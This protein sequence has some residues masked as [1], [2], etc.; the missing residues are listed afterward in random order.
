VRMPPVPML[1]RLIARSIQPLPLAPL[2]LP[3]AL[4]LRS[5]VARHPRIFE[6]L[7]PHASK[8]FGIEPTDLP[9]AFVLEPDPRAPTVIAVRCLPADISIRIAGSM[10]GLL[11]LV[12][13]S[14]DGDALFFSRDLVIKGDVE[15]VLALRNAIDDADLDLVADTAAL[16]GPLAPLG[17]CLLGGALSQ[18]KAL[19][20]AAPR[21]GAESWS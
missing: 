6:R 19:A 17:R 8:R 3:L 18:L 12:D 4:V 20:S 14:Y 16:F 5:V 13:G 9:F 21:T 7:G 1:P 2:Q 11:G 10:M 15:A